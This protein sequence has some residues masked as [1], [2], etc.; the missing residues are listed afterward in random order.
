MADVWKKINR[1]LGAFVQETPN[2]DGSG[3]LAYGHM[4]LAH[5]KIPIVGTYEATLQIN[6][7]KNQGTFNVLYNKQGVQC[8]Y[9]VD[10]ATN[11]RKDI[12]LVDCMTNGQRV[13]CTDA[14]DASS[15]YLCEW[16]TDTSTC[17]PPDSTNSKA[18]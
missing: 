6:Q 12:S 14:T 15:C 16:A 1:D 10:E 18:Q 5:I 8:K 3:S 2:S 4:R 17:T 9:E 11:K 7:D 13:Q